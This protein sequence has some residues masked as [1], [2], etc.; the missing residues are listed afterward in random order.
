MFR[1]TPPRGRRLERLNEGAERAG[2]EIWYYCL[3][4]NHVHLIVAPAD[5]QLRR[6]VQQPLN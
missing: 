6:Q 1:S 3:M 2:S 4:P 5:E